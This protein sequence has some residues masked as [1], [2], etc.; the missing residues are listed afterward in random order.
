MGA[1][2][3]ES[4]YQKSKMTHRHILNVIGEQ[5]RPAPYGLN[6]PRLI[7]CRGDGHVPTSDKYE[8]YTKGYMDRVFGS[9]EYGSKFTNLLP[10]NDDPTHLNSRA[11]FVENTHMSAREKWSRDFWITRGNADKAMYEWLT[12]H[13]N[14]GRRLKA[15][16]N[17]IERTIDVLNMD[18]NPITALRKVWASKT[19]AKKQ[20]E[21]NEAV[22]KA[23]VWA[24]QAG[25]ELPNSKR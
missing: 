11:S 7:A 24:V 4:T 5:L 3:A 21:S 20:T 15:L 6:N 12:N 8:L 2:G 1:R 22:R 9:K 17:G 18:V 25:F 19:Q 10:A 14:H 16:K 13:T 23:E